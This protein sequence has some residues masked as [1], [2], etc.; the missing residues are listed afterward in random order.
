[1]R[2]RRHAILSVAATRRQRTDRF[3]KFETSRRSG[4]ND[5]SR[6]LQPQYRRRVNRRRIGTGA[7]QYVGTVDAGIGDAN[8]DFVG[9]GRG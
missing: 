3:A 7:L 4:L 2:G 5:H 8:Q 9:A 6:H 1:M